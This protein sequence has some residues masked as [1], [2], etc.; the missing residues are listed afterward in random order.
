VLTDPIYTSK[1]IHNRMQNTRIITMYLNE[2]YSKVCIDIHLSDVS[3]SKWSKTRRCFIA[4]AFKLYF[5]IHHYNGP[6]KT[7]RNKI[8]WDT[9]MLMT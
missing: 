5:R 3:Y 1:Y 9:S 2:T 8:E 7:G 4:I 6:R